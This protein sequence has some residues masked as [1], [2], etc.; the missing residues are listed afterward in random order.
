MKYWIHTLFLDFRFV[1]INCLQRRR[2]ESYFGLKQRYWT[3]PIMDKNTNS[4]KS[5]TKNTKSFSVDSI[6]GN[7]ETS[8]NTLFSSLKKLEEC[9]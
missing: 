3:I 7:N 2:S 1:F 6:L 9:K 4:A 5:L 8:N